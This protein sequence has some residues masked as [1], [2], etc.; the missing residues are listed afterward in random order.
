MKT[1]F[2]VLV[3]LAAILALTSFG[4]IFGGGGDEPEM[5]LSALLI[6]ASI[7]CI[8]YLLIDYKNMRPS[9]SPRQLIANQMRAVILPYASGNA[10]TYRWLSDLVNV[11]I[12]MLN[13]M[14]SASAS[15]SPTRTDE[16]AEVLRGLFIK[17]EP[18]FI[19]AYAYLCI[20][21][22]LLYDI[23]SREMNE[24]AKQDKI[25]VYRSITLS[26]LVFNKSYRVP[27]CLVEYYSE[28]SELINV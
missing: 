3:A 21:N 17:S 27:Q 20:L 24:A 23:T 22:D 6:I 5:V 1:R 19:K 7:G 12:L 14:Q 25:E 4:I 11:N 9:K 2:Y 15:L 26:F 28:L 13:G 10:S 8:I 16:S 18:N